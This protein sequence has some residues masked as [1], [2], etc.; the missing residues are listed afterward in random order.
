MSRSN[1]VPSGLRNNILPIVLVAVSFCLA[2][3]GRGND[4]NVV[5]WGKTDTYDS[6]MWE[7]YVPDT[8][9]Q[10]LCFDFNED[11]ENYLT[12]PLKLA[13]FKKDADGHLRRVT[14]DEAELFVNGK[15]AGDNTIVVTSKDKEIDVGIVF[16]DDAENK[17]HYWYIKPVNNPGLDRINDRDSYGEDEAVMEIKLRKR[18][19]MNPLAKGLMWFCFIVLGTLVFW[20]VALKRMFFPTF[21][22]TRLLLTGPE[23]YMSQ[24]KIKGYRLCVLSANPKK[25]NW[26]NKVFTGEI[27][28]ET[29]QLWTAPVTFEPRDRKSVRIRPDRHTYTTDA[30]LLKVNEDYIIVNETTK[31]KTTMRIS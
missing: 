21:R 2:G 4:K 10:T 26:L 20:F 6:F 16:K 27:K 19:V 31:T 30:R 13:V 5:M 29:N 24:L 28:Y 7:K 15:S 12:A 17:V 11:A 9:R 18:H 25:Q 14:T 23:P 1:R 3:C 22:V 8:L